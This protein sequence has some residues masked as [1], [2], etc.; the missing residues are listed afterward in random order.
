VK[1]WTR[2]SSA[3]KLRGAL[4]TTIVADAGSAQLGAEPTGDDDDD[5]EADK[6][7]SDDDVD[8]AR[9]GFPIWEG[10]VVTR[11]HTHTHTHHRTRTH[12][13]TTAH[14]G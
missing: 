3:M 7:R 9:G 14:T 11:P 4:R 2:P 5:D 13:R 6:L 12:A 10:S 1:R 8:S